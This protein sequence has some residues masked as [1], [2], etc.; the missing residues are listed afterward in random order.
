VIDDAVG[1]A[2]RASGLLY[3]LGFGLAMGESAFL[4]DLV[5]PGET[6]MVL[7]GAAGRRADVSLP[8]LIV[9][10]A[11]G[12]TVGDSLGYAVGRRWG[13]GLVHRWDVTSRHL[14]PKLERA[15]RHL[16]RHGGRAVFAARWVGALRAV[17][18]PVAG[19]ARMPYPSFLSW[20]AASA[21]MWTTAMV[22]AG[23]Y[24]G[25][26]ITRAIDRLGWATSAVVVTALVGWFLW[27]RRRRSSTTRPRAPQASRVGGPPMPPQPRRPDCTPEG[28]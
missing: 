21:L 17:V 15:E 13:P 23:W 11:A 20:S 8:L 5:V 28:D 19:A 6:G 4:F 7:V 12:A 26:T 25:E 24:L 2:A 27:R 18:P 3:L 16:A 9:V 10:T 22:S 14:G 1:W